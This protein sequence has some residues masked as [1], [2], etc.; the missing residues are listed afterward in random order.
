MATERQLTDL[1][2]AVSR[3]TLT[4]RLSIPVRRR[5]G[6]RRSFPSEGRGMVLNIKE[7]D[8]GYDMFEME[9][10]CRHLHRS[11]S[12]PLTSCEQ[13]KVNIVR[14]RHRTLTGDRL[15]IG[16]RRQRG[17]EGV[18]KRPLYRLSNPPT[19]LITSERHALPRISIAHSSVDSLVSS[20]VEST[21][22]TTSDLSL[23]VTTS[24]GSGGAGTR[25]S[26]SLSPL[27]TPGL[28]SPSH[29]S[30]CPSPGTRSARSL[31]PVTSEPPSTLRH[32]S[33]SLDALYSSS[34]VRVPRDPMQPRSGSISDV[35]SGDQSAD[36]EGSDFAAPTGYRRN[37]VTWRRRYRVVVMRRR[38]TPPPI[39]YMPRVW[40]E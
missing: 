8:P 33:R 9:N 15:P 3:M 19:S 40:R 1:N 31:S 2:L 18:I 22:T 16:G 30:P 26:R 20:P 10:E 28:R 24:G 29:S 7:A 37:R 5:V 4:N 12:Q 38:P 36:D 39:H 6:R 11:T 13:R 32:A 35:H 21:S 27:S 17:P 34:R 14:R 23:L 25:P